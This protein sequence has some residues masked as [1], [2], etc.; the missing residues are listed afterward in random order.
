LKDLIGILNKSDDVVATEVTQE[1]FHDWATTFKELYT[2]F[3]PVSKYLL[4]ECTA[5]EFVPMKVGVSQAQEV[6]NLKFPKEEDGQLQA[7]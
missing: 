7:K 4:F 2:N 1:D 5:I 3:P 6:V